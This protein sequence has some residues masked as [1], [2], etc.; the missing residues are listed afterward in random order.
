MIV[1]DKWFPQK[2][3]QAVV[4]RIVEVEKLHPAKS[5][6]AQRPVSVLVPCVETKVLKDSADVSVRE[7]KP[8]NKEQ[9]L[10]DFPGAWEYYEKVKGAANVNKV[11]EVPHVEGMPID[12]ADYIPRE[13]LA[14]LKIQGFSTVEQL[15]GMSDA[16]VMSLGPGARNWRKKAKELVTKG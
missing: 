9:L 15:A 1:T 12:R 7:L 5:R 2:G 4:G 11:E 6:E 10:A 14:W 13:K 3:S 16:Q 8:H